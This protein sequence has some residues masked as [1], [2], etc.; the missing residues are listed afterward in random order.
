MTNAKNYMTDIFALL[1]KLESDGKIC[2]EVASS[3]TAVAI[4]EDGLPVLS[5][6]SWHLH[7]HPE[8]TLTFDQLKAA[9]KTSD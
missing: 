5:P 1:E 3:S 9:A 8:G 4:G 7:I 6:P 2:Y